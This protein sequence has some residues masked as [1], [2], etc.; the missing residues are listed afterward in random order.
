MACIVCGRTVNPDFNY[1][2]RNCYHN[3]KHKLGV[4]RNDFRKYLRHGLGA[5]LYIPEEMNFKQVYGILKKNTRHY[6]NLR[7]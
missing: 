5:H 1:V 7:I 6:L 4:S 3:L 2:C